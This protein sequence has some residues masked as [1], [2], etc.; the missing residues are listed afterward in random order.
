[1]LTYLLANLPHTKIGPYQWSLLSLCGFGW[2]ADN[3]W[4]QA[5]AII[6]PRVQ[7]H[8]AVPDSYIGILSFSMFFGMMFGAVGWGTCSDLIG[9]S[10]AFN[11][12]LFFTALFGVLA[13]FAP[14]FFWLCVALFFL[15]SAVGGSMPT[16]GTLLLEHMP[17]GKRYLLTALSVFFS[18]GAVLSA[19]VG[20]IIIPR[21]SCL[22]TSSDPCSPESNMGWK[23]MLII[24][25]LIT[26]L[27]FV[28]RVAF[29]RL[30][31]SPRYLVH[32][33]RPHDAVLSLRKISEFNGDDLAIDL[34]NVEDRREAVLFA[35]EDADI[36]AIES[37]PCPAKRYSHD[38]TND[39]A[40]PTMNGAIHPNFNY[41]AT[42]STPSPPNPVAYEDAPAGS[43]R[44]DDGGESET[45]PFFSVHEIKTAQSLHRLPCWARRPISAWLSRLAMVLSKEWRSTTLLVWWIWFAI[46]LAYT[47]F[48]VYL[49][50][51][52]E[53]RSTTNIGS[54]KTLEETMWD[55]VIFTLGGCPGAILGAYLIQSR[56]GRRLSLS[57][58]TLTTA[59][60]CVFFVTV[61]SRWAVRASTVGISLSA[62]TMWAVLYGMT[63]E[64]FAT[65]V[66]GTACGTA[67]AL[68][69]VGGMLAPLA[70][71][72][73]LVINT[74]FP[75]YAS[76]VV[77]T[78]GG[79]CVLPLKVGDVPGGNKGRLHRWV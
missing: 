46:S 10:T 62:T 73:L 67:S 28:A 2:M 76:I 38:D 47:M 37:V 23:Y 3:C 58:S 14:N 69:R 71:G 22:T 63:P 20:I 25:G 70:G 19:L 75:V 1:M 53:T 7:Q 13:G 32:A 29:F 27:M 60:F 42:E 74:S 4:I 36:E 77:F 51:L 43:S 52:L 44:M 64:I 9:R 18:L 5:T 40:E 45:D 50:K 78:A 30:H 55:V 35:A 8:Y 41:H 59:G 26:L 6:L 79:L 49:P 12:T 66:R 31:E 61:D 16:D 24:L 57:F 33:G 21:Y 68:S 15:G 39:H 48:N 72:A 65:E 56:L 17:N 11:A 34:G 54:H